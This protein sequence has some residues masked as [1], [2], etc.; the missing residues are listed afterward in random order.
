MQIRKNQG[1]VVHS[2]LSFIFQVVE[3]GGSLLQKY[4]ATTASFIP[5]RGVTPLVLQPQLIVSDPDGTVATADYV[6]QMR[7]VSW[8]LT[9]MSGGSSST[10]PAT[11]GAVTNYAVDSTTKR[12]TLFRNVQ[13]QEVVHVRFFGQYLDARRNEVFDFE[14]TRDCSTE[15]QTDLN[16]TLDAGRWRS[17]VRMIPMRRWG[18]FGIPVQLKNGPENIADADASYQ[19]QWWNAATNAWSEDFSEQAWLVSGEQT[20]EITV[21]QDF[22]QDVRLRVMA[23]A[24]GNVNTAQYFT[25]RLQRWYGQFDYDVEFLR[26]KY[27]FHD[28]DTVV[29]NAW[30]ANAKGKISSPCMYFDMELFFAIGT[31]D[32][33]SVGYGEEVIIKRNGLQGGQP[34]AGIL[35]RE[36]SAFRALCEDN[37]TPLCLDDGTPLFAQ[38]P[39]KSRQV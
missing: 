11:S 24:F 27:I 10:L 39:T 13:P 16:I 7:N 2:S 1:R 9:L 19:W 6:S 28:T 38:F 14:W 34:K 37:G 33:E 21:D 36:L 30:V 15:V 18:Q 35:L 32:F 31:G 29:L 23:I 5:H 25:T 17:K 3:M 26:G 20:K 22:I 4:D 8:E 12:L